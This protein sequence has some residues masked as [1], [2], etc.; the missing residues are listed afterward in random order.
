MTDN[1]QFEKLQERNQQA[2]NNISQLQQQEKELYSSLE[3]VSLT[4][5]QKQQIINKINEITQIRMNLYESL[6]DLYSNYKENVSSSRG[7]LNQ[8]KAAIDI[9]ENELNDA[10]IKM[11]MI[12]TEKYNRLRLVEINTYYGKR[13]NAHSEIMK[14]IVF[15]CIPI[16]LFSILYNKQIL[17][18]GIYTILIVITFI[19][20]ST[21]LFLKIIDISNRD[22]MNWDEYNWYFNKNDAPDQGTGD[23]SSSNNPWQTRNIP[24]VGAACCD[25]N[26][27]YDSAQNICIPNT[28]STEGFSSVF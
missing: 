7:T 21:Y 3:D 5:D 23:S 25:E 6:R 11:N 20:G 22:T 10:K 12:E 4:S 14:I 18:S 13:F 24:C 15:T 16:I 2:L 9:L 17:S 1:S 26:S 27:T 19:I 8:S 28:T